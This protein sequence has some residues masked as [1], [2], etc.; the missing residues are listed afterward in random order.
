M[1]EQKPKTV[2]E[3]QA[4]GGDVPE[5][6]TGYACFSA[7]NWNDFRLHKFTPKPFGP[8]DIDIKVEYCG[9]CGSD[10]HTLRSGWSPTIYPVVV[11]HEVTGRVVRVG[12]NVTSVTPGTYV[13]VGSQA[14]SCGGCEA[15]AGDAG[16]RKDWGPDGE[17]GYGG[18]GGLEGGRENYCKEV[19]ET[20]NWRYKDGAL[21]QGGFADYIRIHENFVYPI[22]ESIP[23]EVAA[24]LLCGGLT[25]FS[26][27]TRFPV[28]PNTSVGIIGIGGLGHYGLQFA[29]T[30]GAKVAAISHSPSKRD[31]A[32]ALGATNFIATN[33]PN[34]NVPHARSI[35]LLISTN[36]SS[37]M[38]LKE[39]LSL[40]KIGGTLVMCGIPEGE[41]PRLSW[42]DLASA[43][44]AIRGSNVG[45][46][47]EVLEMLKLVKER[48]LRGWVQVKDMADVK[49]VVTD[50][51]AGKGRYRWVL[52]ADF[53]GK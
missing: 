2:V 50:L 23:P 26:P 27:L 29:S 16:V 4:Q 42:A 39:Y 41:L 43:N 15:C 52:K 44:L 48:G 12:P 18:K 37:D 30:L 31:D 25:M 11:G 32:L 24:P 20:Y 38:P 14:W 6:F 10:L 47:K 35:D 7:E 46:K 21:A 19:V 45:S 8:W 1:A 17:H 5:Q 28:T 34:W 22:P 9:V 53:D 3:L 49:E 33:T 13:G 40:L 51:E 36:F